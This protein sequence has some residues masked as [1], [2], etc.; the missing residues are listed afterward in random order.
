MH[1][2]AFHVYKV[3]PK[4]FVLSAGNMGLLHAIRTSAERQMIIF[5]KKLKKEKT[6]KYNFSHKQNTLKLRNI[7]SVSENA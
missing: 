7:S 5:F 6:L 3:Q 2:K 1:Q 4:A